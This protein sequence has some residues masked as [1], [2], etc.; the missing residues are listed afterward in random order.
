MG[1]AAAI[2]VAMIVNVWPGRNLPDLFQDNKLYTDRK[3]DLFSSED[4]GLLFHFSL[5]RTEN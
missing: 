5:C 1:L 3:T 2:T 4:L